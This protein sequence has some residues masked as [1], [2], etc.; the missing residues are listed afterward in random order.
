M[1]FMRRPHPVLLALLLLAPSAEAQ[2]RIAFAPI[3]PLQLECKLRND[4]FWTEI[5][6]SVDPASS[7][8]TGILGN[9]VFSGDGSKRFIS[10]N[11]LF[12]IRAMESVIIG[13][14]GD[15]RGTV[16]RFSLMREESNASR[17]IYEQTDPTG[18][19]T[20]ANFKCFKVRSRQK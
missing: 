2:P 18:E 7:K 12:D 13:H 3:D 14:T 9:Y 15:P 17:W 5:R 11:V 6:F 10:G 4:R 1:N 19:K 8:V 20:V 16:S